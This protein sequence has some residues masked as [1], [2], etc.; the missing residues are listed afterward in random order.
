MGVASCLSVMRGDF[1]R[2]TSVRSMQSVHCPESTTSARGTRALKA[3]V[4]VKCTTYVAFPKELLLCIRLSM[5]YE[6]D[7][8]VI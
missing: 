5:F 4:M 1:L 2:T 8:I 6:Y 3:R 7:L